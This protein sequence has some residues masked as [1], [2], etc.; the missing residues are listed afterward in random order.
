MTNG[1]IVMQFMRELKD[2]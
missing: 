2:A 1:N